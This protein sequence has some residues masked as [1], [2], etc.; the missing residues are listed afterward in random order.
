MILIRVN[1][2]ILCLSIVWGVTRF[3]LSKVLCHKDIYAIDH[4]YWFISI[5]VLPLSILEKAITAH[6]TVRVAL[7]VMQ[8]VPVGNPVF[9]YHRMEDVLMAFLFTGIL[10]FLAIFV[11]YLRKCRILNESFPIDADELRKKHPS[12]DLEKVWVCEYITSP[13][14]WGI[15][16]PKILIPPVLAKQ[17][18]EQAK[19]ILLHEWVHLKRK[20]NFVKCLALI[21]VCMFWYHPYLWLFYTAFQ[22]EAEMSCDEAVI[23]Y[24]GESQ[25]LE[26]A[27]TLM[28]FASQYSP[29]KTMISQLTSGNIKR[30]ILA[31]TNYKITDKKFRIFKKLSIG[32]LIV[33]CGMAISFSTELFAD[34][35]RPEDI[36]VVQEPQEGTG[37]E[38]VQGIETEQGSQEIPKISAEQNKELIQEEQDTLSGE[39]VQGESNIDYHSMTMEELEEIIDNPENSDDNRAEALHTYNRKYFGLEE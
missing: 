27:R 25:K 30:R 2:I 5:L 36:E 13:M 20:D 37:D 12:Q 9:N 38:I 8:R 28:Q 6:R 10:V 29:Q 31:V 7:P 35:D 17:Y 33:F 23:G 18:D 34:V 1:L 26:Y 19:Q 4:V 14:V 24:L 22:R 3:V 32:M 21:H 39:E 11:C 16:R 15:I